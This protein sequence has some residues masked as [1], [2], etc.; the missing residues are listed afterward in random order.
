MLGIM[1]GM[2]LMDCGALIVDSGSVQD[3]FCWFLASICVPFG[4]RQALGQVGLDQNQNY[5]V[6][7]FY[8]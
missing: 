1:A 7:W 5:A 2:D 8:W 3:Q 4:C 6:G